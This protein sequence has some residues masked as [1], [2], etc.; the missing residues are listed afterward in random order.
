MKNAFFM[1]LLL[2]ALSCGAGVTLHFVSGWPRITILLTIA[3]V[4][5]FVTKFADYKISQLYGKE[6]GI[7]RTFYVA[8]AIISTWPLLAC[9]V[10]E[11]SHL[12]DVAVVTI[13]LIGICIG[14]A[15]QGSNN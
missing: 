5:A 3:V 2:V 6:L 8:T 10:T 1:W 14:R 13:P 15:L 12:A 11:S 9:V 4:A 7:I